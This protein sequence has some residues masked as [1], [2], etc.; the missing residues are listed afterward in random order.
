MSERDRL[1]TEFGSYAEWLAQAIASLSLEDPIPAACRGTGNPALF[2][3]LA[4]RMETRPGMRI[5]DVGCGIG[6]PGA[7][8]M[9]ERGCRVVGVDVMQ[10]ALRGLKLLFPDLPTVVASTGALPFSSDS[11]EGVWMLG[12]LEVIENKAAALADLRRVLSRGGRAVLYSFMKTEEELTEV[13]EVDHFVR[14]ED[15][16]DMASSVGLELTGRERVTVPKMPES[17]R[18]V[19]SRVRG[20]LWELHV[21]DPL[22]ERVE[23]DLARINRLTS[24][25]QVEPWELVFEKGTS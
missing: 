19:R 7:W 21:G 11:F 23:L 18:D 16:A 6:G 10:P 2:E 4:D 17:W 5:L 3:R 15:V 20:R 8:L 13:P 25:R 9:H 22:L 12:V 14:P 24:S 1:E